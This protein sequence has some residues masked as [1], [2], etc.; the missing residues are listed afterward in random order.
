VP[1]SFHGPAG[2][3]GCLRGGNGRYRIGNGNGNGAGVGCA[4]VACWFR[5]FCPLAIR[6]ALALSVLFIMQPFADFIAF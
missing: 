4:V 1:G 6:K 2:T 3:L 5:A